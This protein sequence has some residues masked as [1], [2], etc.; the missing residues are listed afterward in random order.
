M[1]GLKPNEFYQLTPSETYFY[2]KGIQSDYDRRYDIAV[3]TWQ[4]LRWLGAMVHN[5]SMRVKSSKSP[6][7]LLTLPGETQKK[8]VKMSEEDKK[9]LIRKGNKVLKQVING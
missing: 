1:A 4:V 3:S 2:L 9:E 7:S 6:A 5:T 8:V